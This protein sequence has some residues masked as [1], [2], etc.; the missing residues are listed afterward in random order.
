MNNIPV[1]CVTSNTVNLAQ[2]KSNQ[3]INSY[4]SYLSHNRETTSFSYSSNSSTIASISFSKSSNTLDL[5]QNH[6]LLEDFLSPKNIKCL[7]R[8]VIDQSNQI[9]SCLSEFISFDRVHL[10]VNRTEETEVIFEWFNGE[11]E[12][13]V[14]V[15][16]ESIDYIKAWGTNIHTEMEDGILD[17]PSSV[18]SLWQW[19][20]N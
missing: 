17:N 2:N 8:Q 5:S 13:S 6:V 3:L 15:S 11:K 19:L 1:N 9:L 4:H 16:D 18:R 12:L 10:I 20:V 7:S 14:Y